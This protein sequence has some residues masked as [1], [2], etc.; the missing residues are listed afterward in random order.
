MKNVILIFTALFILGSC[1]ER[2]QQYFESSPEIDIV[3]KGNEAFF[4]KDWVALRQAYSDSARLAENV[5]EEDR[6]IGI[7]QYIESS[8]VFVETL[9]E[10]KMSDDAIYLM[11]IGNEGDKWVLNWFNFIAVTKDGK[12]VK[13]PININLRFVDRKIIFQSSMY[14]QLPLFMA[15]QAGEGRY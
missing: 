9:A 13:T 7:D 15:L 5:W 12:E 2:E 1:K 14:D 11:V 4:K 10:Y 8:K 6:W 3:K